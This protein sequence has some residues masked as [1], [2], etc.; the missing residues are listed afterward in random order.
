M[1]RKKVAELT[2]VIGGIRKTKTIS[3]LNMTR[4]GIMYCDIVEV[5][6]PDIFIFVGVVCVM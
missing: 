5:S 2:R 1:E 4:P 6:E 3:E